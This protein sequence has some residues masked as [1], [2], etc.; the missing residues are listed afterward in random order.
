MKTEIVELKRKL[1]NPSD[2]RQLR[3]FK[4]AENEIFRLR[5]IKDELELSFERRTKEFEDILKLHTVRF[6]F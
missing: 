3:I 5:A 6:L 1:E 4:E 2:I